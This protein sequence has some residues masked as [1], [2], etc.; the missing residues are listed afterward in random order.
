MLS[1]ISQWHNLTTDKEVFNGD[2]GQ[3]TEVDEEEGVL[4]VDYDGQTVEYKFGELDEV[5][6]AYTT[7]IHESHGLNIPPWSFLWRCSTTLCCS[8]T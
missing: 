1:E 8:G 5:S 3:I 7:T 4:R 2:I 6:L